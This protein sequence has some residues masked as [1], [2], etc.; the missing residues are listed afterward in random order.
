[1]PSGLPSEDFPNLETDAENLP[2]GFGELDREMILELE[3]VLVR[4]PRAGGD[5]GLDVR[6]GRLAVDVSGDS[7]VAEF[8][9][10]AAAFLRSMMGTEDK[11]SDF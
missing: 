8:A 3:K 2:F 5:E 1:L 9:E 6:R 11:F 7:S 10:T 4:E